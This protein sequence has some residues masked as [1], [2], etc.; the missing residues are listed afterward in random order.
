M[1]LVYEASMDSFPASDPPGWICTH[2]ATDSEAAASVVEEPRLLARVATPW[3]IA[4]AALGVLAA[5]GAL[6][7]VV[8]RA[9]R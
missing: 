1:D 8:M 6:T 9:R 7:F 2:A 3:K 4:V 5:V